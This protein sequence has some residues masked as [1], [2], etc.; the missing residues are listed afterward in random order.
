MFSALITGSLLGFVLAMPPGPIAMANIRLGLEKNRKD[1]IYFSIGTATMDLIYCLVAIS[2]ASAIYSVVK[3]YLDDN[4]I[5]SLIIQFTIV[6]GLVFF[7]IQ[8]FKS[9]NE[10]YD[11]FDKPIR[12]SK[13]LNS[14]KNRGPM[15]L[16][17]SL[18]FTNLANPTFLPSLTVMS[19][20]VRK[21]GVF[22]DSLLYDL[23][24]SFGFG[25]GNFIWLYILSMLVLKNRHKL[26]DNSIIR[27]K[28]FAGVTF[29][30]FGGLLGYRVIMFTNWASIF[31]FAF[32]F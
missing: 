12:Q 31:K 15:F 4:P 7:G 1:C 29:I 27:I 26:S 20:W 10:S 8:Q 17:I 30:G 2:A 21:I 32:V 16:G 5:I 28:Q 6:A 23:I 22:Q 14:L 24:F 13:F 25:V 18:A 9:R 11:N 19:T 3:G